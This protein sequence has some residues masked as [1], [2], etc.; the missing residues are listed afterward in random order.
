MGRAKYVIKMAVKMSKINFLKTF[1]NILNIENQVFHF[2]MILEKI[3]N[4]KTHSAKTFYFRD[5]LI[6]E[7]DIIKRKIKWSNPNP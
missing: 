6:D 7:A 2:I 1:K 4:N 5:V 3:K